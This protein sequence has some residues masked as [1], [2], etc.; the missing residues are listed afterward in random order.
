[1][2]RRAAA[3]PKDGPQANVEQILGTALRVNVRQRAMS[4]ALPPRYGDCVRLEVTG[5]DG[6]PRWSVSFIENVRARLELSRAEIRAQCDET[7]E[8][9]SG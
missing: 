2:R 5:A 8:V 3:V 7:K 6:V 1:M 9:A 4:R